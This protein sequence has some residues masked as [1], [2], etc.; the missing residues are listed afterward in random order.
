MTQN[1]VRYMQESEEDAKQRYRMIEEGREEGNKRRGVS[2][3]EEGK[4]GREMNFVRCEFI[5]DG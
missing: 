1:Q 2:I 4:W 5:K 3:R